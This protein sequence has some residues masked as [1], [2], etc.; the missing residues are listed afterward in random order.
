[1]HI[2]VKERFLPNEELAINAGL[3]HYNNQQ[4]QFSARVPMAISAYSAN[5]ELAGAL[6]GH[7]FFDWLTVSRLWV[8]PEQ[9][10]AGVGKALLLE[11]EGYAKNQGCVG[12]TL[13]TYDFQAR[14]FYEKLGYAVFGVL[15]NNPK[16]S[17]RYFMQKPL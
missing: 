16:G 14:P 7:V 17:E 6:D 4:G 3:A 5:G 2:I 13:S 15:P 8:C 12:S 10:G 11:A 9:R 1:M